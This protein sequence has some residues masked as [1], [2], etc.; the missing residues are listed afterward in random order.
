MSKRDAAVDVESV[1][2]EA[3]AKTLFDRIGDYLTAKDWDFYSNAERHF[4]SFS[5][6][7]RDGNVRVM[8][9]ATEVTS[10]SR[11]LVYTTFQ[12]FVPEQKRLAVAE[13]ISRINYACLFGNMEMDLRDGEVRVRTILEDEGHIG[14][15][16]IDRAVRRG[17]D[18]ADQYQAALL[19]I[20]FGN[21]QAKDILD[22]ASRDDG[23][24]LQ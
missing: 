24:T 16:M 2:V 10:W 8:I 21:A 3:Q 11:I 1:V 14:E 23:A 15:S 20:A 5:L 4:F 12:T 22:L 7:L 6:R 9:E 13:A 18:M 17:L 19:S